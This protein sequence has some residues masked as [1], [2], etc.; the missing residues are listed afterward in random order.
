MTS[1]GY[2]NYNGMAAFEQRL[3][4]WGYKSHGYWEGTFQAAGRANGEIL[5]TSGFRCSKEASG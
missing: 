3:R 5:S 2:W 4:A 1:G